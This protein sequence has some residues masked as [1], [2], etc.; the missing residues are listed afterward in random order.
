[1]S[2]FMTV[3]DKINV[4]S[5]DIVVGLSYGFDQRGGCDLHDRAGGA[6]I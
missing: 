2:S 4:L 6:I 1:M 5:H 3:V